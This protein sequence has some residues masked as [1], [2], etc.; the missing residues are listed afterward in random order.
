MH[1]RTAD[2]PRPESAGERTAF[3]ERIGPKNLAPLWEVI[4]SLVPAEPQSVCAPYRWRYAETRPHLIEACKLISAQ[5]AE[6]RVL[7]LENPALR[8]QSRVTH[9]L[10]AGLQIIMPGEIAPPHRHVAAALRLI[11]EGR[12][13]YT[14]VDG[15]RTTMYPGDFVITPSFTWHDH[16]HP[17][18]GPMVWLDGLDM[19]MVNFF[20]ASFRESDESRAPHRP[21][22]SEGASLARFGNGMLPMGF[23]TA[24]KTSPIF[25]YPYRRTRA[26]LDMMQRTDP[27][28]DWHGQRV[29]YVNPVNG[30]DAIPTIATFMQL[31][32]KGFVTKPYRSTA[33]TVFVVVEG[34]GQT[35][36]GAETLDWQQHDVFVVPSWMTCIH[37]A[38]SEAVLFSYSDCGVQQKLGFWRE[39]KLAQ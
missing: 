3:Y 7:V 24:G 12:G 1:A 10:F 17:G 18:D 25:N 23:E 5:E 20:E 39:E 16:G 6:R 37:S 27:I 11:I 13:A 19:H 38:T 8:G 29:R 14:S 30:D 34:A 2:L 33:S 21:V 15:E 32:P 4:R 36:V 26:A 9:T 31:L 35:E 22:R 28:D